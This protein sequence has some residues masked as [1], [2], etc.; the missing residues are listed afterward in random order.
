MKKL[1]AAISICVM[2]F[3]AFLGGTKTR[4]YQPMLAEQESSQVISSSEQSS[5]EN[6]QQESE[7]KPGNVAQDVIEVV[8]TIFNQKIVIF[9]VSFSLGTLLVWVLGKIIVG[10]LSNKSSKQ[11]KKIDELLKKL[12]LKEEEIKQ[13]KADSEKLDGIIKEIIDN[14]KNIKVKE[15]LIAMY[16][17]K[18][19]Q[20]E[21]VV[22]EN[23][24]Q[25]VNLV[26]TNQETIKELLEKK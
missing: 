9:G 19:E 21:Q 4:S 20:V 3:C 5:S 2:S 25:V 24:E 1:F 12:G 7:E 18:V 16:E 22:E 10:F 6:E 17:P 15:K 14:T 23:K 13:L 8:K 11:D 26:K